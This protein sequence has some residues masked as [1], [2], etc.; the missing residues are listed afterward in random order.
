MEL[1]LGVEKFV[2]SAGIICFR[3]I[4]LL[5]FITIAFRDGYFV[6]ETLPL[7]FFTTNA[8]CFE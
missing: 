3:D 1:Q 8:P 4:K 2:T 7:E 6:L 5:C